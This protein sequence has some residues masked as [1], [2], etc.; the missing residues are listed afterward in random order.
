ASL[1]GVPL[2]SSC[3]AYSTDSVS[4]FLYPF[5]A[6]KLGREL[7]EKHGITDITCQ[8]ASLTAMAGVALKERFKRRGLSLEIQVHEDLGSPNYGF[9]LMNRLRRRLAFR[10]LPKADHIRVVSERIK[11]FIVRRLAIDPAKIE[12]RPIAVDAGWLK[13]APVIPGA[14]LR[15]KHPQFDKIVLMVGRLEP[16]KD[17]ELAI[18]SWPLVLKALPKAGLVIVGSGSRLEAL[19]ERAEKVG[20][21]DSIAFE[22]WG[23]NYLA[24]YYKSCDL[25]LVTSLFEGYGMALKEAQAAGCRIVSTDVGIAREAGA[26]IVGWDPKSVADG[27]VR[28]LRV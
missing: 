16:E 19:K 25:F 27:I 9:T 7:I 23:G 1:E 14:D 12:V 26:E 28:T 17:F 13:D 11:D 10:N 3:F 6:K 20:A 15:M 22:G 5:D 18:D 2:S 8:D 24:S 21:G 4:R